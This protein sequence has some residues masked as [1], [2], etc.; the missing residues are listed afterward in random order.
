MIAELLTITDAAYG[1]A[2][3]VTTRHVFAQLLN[4]VPV[5]HAGGG[6]FTPVANDLNGSWSYQRIRGNVEVSQTSIPGSPCQGVRVLVPLRIVALLPR[7]TCMESAES[8]MAALRNTYASAAVAIGANEVRFDRVSWALAES[9]VGEFSPAPQIPT[10]K[11]L[12]II[13][14]SIA[15]I[16]TQECITGCD[17][18]DVTC[19]IIAAASVAKIRECLGDRLNDV[20]DGG[21]PCPPT[22]VNGAESDTPA[23]TVVQ[24]GEQV[25]TLN[26][27]TGVHTVPECDPCPVPECDDLVDAVVV[28]G[29]GLENVNGLY[30]RDDSE[31]V[32][33][34]PDIIT[35]RYTLTGPPQRVIFGTEI[36]PG[37]I[38]WTIWCV[39]DEQTLYDTG[40]PSE[41]PWGVEWIDAQ[42]NP[43]APTVR[44]ATI[45]DLCPC[46]DVVVEVNGEAYAT[47]VSGGSVDIPVTNSA[48]TQIGTVT[49]GVG[50]EVADSNLYTTDGLVLVQGIPAEQPFNLPQ[51][52]IKFKDAANVDQI[53]A[54][55][56]TNF[57]NPPYL[58]PALQIP[59]R[60]FKLT[61]GAAL[62][63]Y[64]D[65]G[66]LIADSLPTIPQTVYATWGDG[67]GETLGVVLPAAMQGVP[68]S[69]VSETG[70]SGT[71]TV[72]VN[73]GTTFAAPPFTA[74]VAK[75]LFKRTVSTLTSTATF[76]TA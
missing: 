37:E 5:V 45:A 31:P 48:A 64:A 17:P 53:T 56:N 3:P 65:A 54:P 2:L 71:I 44:Q 74:G 4:G 15:V 33:D 41:D 62:P 49:P 13:D 12:L 11:A 43:P 38:L 61:G 26:P 30:R 20:C 39:P 72:S 36:N 9:A 32:P 76:T 67:D 50:V 52:V 40:T 8:A 60:Q 51:S 6:Q 58:N 27:A 59:R 7:D 16:A 68:F 29:A 18:V 24:G 70:T 63:I 21:G 46:E 73:G 10:S 75:V 1:A 23:I 57:E 47:V 28:E 25:G 66:A 42:D 22:T 69:F 55:S 35:R 14:L 34:Y 19:S